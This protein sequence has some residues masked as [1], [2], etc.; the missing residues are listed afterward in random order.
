MKDYMNKITVV[1]TTFN[2]TDFTLA[3][4]HSIDR[5]Y[6]IGVILADGGSDSNEIEKIEDNIDRFK[7]LEIDVIY[8]AGALT[9]EIRN[10]A[11][12]LCV[13][14][15][16][17][18]FMDNDVK[19]TANNCI[20]DLL[21]VFDN[22][23]DCV[24]HTGAYGGKIVD[25]EKRISFVGTEFDEYFDVDFMP[26]YFSLHKTKFYKEVG[27][28]P[29]RWL[30]PTFDESGNPLESTNGGDLT[31]GLLYKERALRNVT[32]KKTVQVLHWISPLRWKLDRP[33]E[34]SF[35]S[36]CTH[37]RVNPLNSKNCKIA[38]ENMKT[39]V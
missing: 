12:D 25:F 18:L 22:N 35:R 6:K 3:S 4:L 13:D 5:Y 17:I 19:M 11:V 8:K 2:N 30:Y 32:P 24:A 27:G 10:L 33:I 21:D 37:I 9:E 7:N 34:D 16:Y 26:C 38:F 1:M 29:K 23:D 14:T 36:D 15:K 31:I 20:E 28:M 39:V